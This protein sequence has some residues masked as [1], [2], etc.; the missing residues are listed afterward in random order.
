[1]YQDS[2]DP[3]KYGLYVKTEGPK[4]REAKNEDYA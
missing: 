3:S 4:N 2:K 1:M